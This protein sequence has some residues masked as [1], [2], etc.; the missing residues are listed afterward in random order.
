MEK[1]PT[2]FDKWREP[3][4]NVNY[5]FTEPTKTNVSNVRARAGLRLLRKTEPKPKKPELPKKRKWKKGRKE[6]E[7]KENER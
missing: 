1:Q 5:K 7:K 6:K 2:Y 4:E 3:K